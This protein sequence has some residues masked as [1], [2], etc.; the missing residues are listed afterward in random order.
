MGQ[1]FQALSKSGRDS[2][3]IAAK[4][5]TFSRSLPLSIFL[6]LATM[7]SAI[8]T[9]DLRDKLQRTY[10]GQSRSDVVSLLGTPATEAETT[11]LGITYLKLRWQAGRSG[12]VVTVRLLAGRLVA[13]EYCERAA[14]C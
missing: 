11:V 12:P 10:L 13:S 4:R 8:A 3:G 1:H 5:C 6:M 9:D 7:P 14:D 2:G